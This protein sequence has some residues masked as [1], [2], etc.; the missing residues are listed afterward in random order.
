M[1]VARLRFSARQH[2]ND[3]ILVHNE[4]DDTISFFSLLVIIF[5]STVA[6]D[7][8]IIGEVMKAGIIQVIIFAIILMLLTQFSFIIFA[9]TWIYTDVITFTG[10]WKTCFG[11]AFSKIPLL[12]IVL[13]F[14][15]F[16]IYHSWE[17]FDNLKN[18]VVSLSGDLS[19][20]VL[21]NQWFVSY[22]ICFVV[23]IPTLCFPKKKA[24][25]YLSYV[26]SFF[27]LVSFICVIVMFVKKLLKGELIHTSDLSFWNPSIGTTIDCISEFN[28]LFFCHPI[29]LTYIP[30]LEN[31]TIGRSI[32]MTWISS[33][34][35]LITTLIVLLLSYLMVPQLED[36]V[37]VFF[38]F[39]P[40]DPVVI[41]GKAS[42]YMVILCS[43]MF[44]IHFLAIELV[45]V[46]INA[47]DIDKITSLIAGFV[48]LSFSV[49]MNFMDEESYQSIEF[50]GIIS[51]IIV[52]FIFPA[53]FYLKIFGRQNKIFCSIAIFLIVIGI[54]FLGLTIFQFYFI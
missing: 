6:T 17:V 50:I 41:A 21:T 13:G 38:Y 3:I 14:I 24:M 20:T 37:N 23:C 18:L 51:M 16:T 47:K 1:N 44:Y 36:E 39:D 8:F 15:N 42:Q 12:L 9:S 4:N 28:T 29:V 30:I 49:A 35:V 34:I 54:V 26:K 46:F 43:I 45:N 19:G 27:L 2:T 33:I 25:M 32:K 53:I 48:A 31:P 10:I 11:P 22:L 5:S 7:P 40:T 52:A